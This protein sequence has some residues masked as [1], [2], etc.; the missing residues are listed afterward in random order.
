MCVSC[1]MAQMPTD[2]FPRTTPKSS[3][4]YGTGHASASV[5]RW[6]AEAKVARRVSPMDA[7]VRKPVATDFFSFFFLRRR[8]NGSSDLSGRGDSLQV[9]DIPLHNLSP[10]PQ[11]GFETRKATVIEG[12]PALCVRRTNTRFRNSG[13]FHMIQRYW[14]FLKNQVTTPCRNQDRR[15]RDTIWK[16]SQNDSGCRKCSTI[17]NP[18]TER[19]KTSANL[20]VLVGRQLPTRSFPRKPRQ[21]RAK[22]RERCVRCKHPSGRVTG[23]SPVARRA[24]PHSVDA[25]SGVRRGAAPPVL[26]APDFRAHSLIGRGYPQ[27]SQN[28]LLGL[29]TKVYVRQ[30]HSVTGARGTLPGAPSDTGVTNGSPAYTTLYGAPYRPQRCYSS[31]KL[32]NDHSPSRE[33]ALALSKERSHGSLLKSCSGIKLKPWQR[34]KILE[35]HSK[36]AL[37]KRATDPECNEFFGDTQFSVSYS[38]PTLLAVTSQHITSHYITSHHIT[39]LNITLHYTTL[40]PITTFAPWGYDGS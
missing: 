16:K 40:H 17:T 2:A 21:L 7:L 32:L 6:M 18:T 10:S 4:Q 24:P 36:Q 39:S 33:P 1:L 37:A 23:P 14:A 19:K 31:S 30:H 13:I 28:N 15:P 22:P 9:E 12:T 29:F 25:L 8:Q 35:L 11:R 5:K 38:P 27:T 3:V 34:V 26:A 20:C